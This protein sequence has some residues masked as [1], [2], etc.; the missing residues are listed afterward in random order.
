MLCCVWLITFSF[1]R[2]SFFMSRVLIAKLGLFSKD[3]DW[4]VCGVFISFTGTY[5]KEKCTTD[6]EKGICEP[7]K[8]GTYAEH[9]TGMDQCLQCSQCPAGNFTSFICLPERSL[10]TRFIQTIKV[11]I[12]SF[13]FC[14]KQWSSTEN[15]D[16]EISSKLHSSDV[17]IGLEFRAAIFDP[18]FV[19]LRGLLIHVP[20]GYTLQQICR[21]SHPES[22]RPT[23]VAQFPIG[24]LMDTS[25]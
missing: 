20:S 24:L 22:C 3:K 25:E 18:G 9:P 13:L 23:P 16:W 7:C 6:Q 17:I 10:W 11:V 2:H 14:K 15:Q 4:D 5:V 8:E 1:H 21:N 12:V 19:C